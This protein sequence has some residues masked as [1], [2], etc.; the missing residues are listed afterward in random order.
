[1]YLP[2]SYASICECIKIEQ[3][4]QF[5]IIVVKSASNQPL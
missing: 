2:V 3:I 1:M 5:S 4:K